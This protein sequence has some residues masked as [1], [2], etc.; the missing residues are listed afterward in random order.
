MRRLTAL[1]ALILFGCLGAS[2]SAPSADLGLPMPAITTVSHADAAVGRGGGGAEGEG[3][4]QVQVVSRISR[5]FEQELPNAFFPLV[6]IG[7]GWAA[8]QRNA[9]AAVGTLVFAVVVGPFIF[10]PDQLESLFNALYR[11]VL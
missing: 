1:G 7:L 5:W 8:L 3:G 11:F 4:A 2:L 10:A 9:G 6:A